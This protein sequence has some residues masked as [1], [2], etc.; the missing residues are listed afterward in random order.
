MRRR[1]KRSHWPSGAWMNRGT[2]RSAWRRASL[3]AS[4]VLA[5][6]ICAGTGPT[7]ATSAPGLNSPPPHLRQG[8][9]RSALRLPLSRSA[10]GAG[11]AGSLPCSERRALRIRF[12]EGRRP[13]DW[14]Y[15]KGLALDGFIYAQGTRWP[16]T[17]SIS[18]SGRA[19]L[20]RRHGRPHLL[21]D[22]AH[23]AHICAGTEWTC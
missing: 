12:A 18:R 4:K 7:L 20:K 2:M 22:W 19:S 8:F 21:R 16:R 13:I 14:S 9:A 6:H 11:R 17:I 10:D 1:W 23:P 15:S 5:V 3:S